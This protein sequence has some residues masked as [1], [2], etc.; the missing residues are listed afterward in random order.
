MEL[1]WSDDSIERSGAL[2]ALDK[3]FINNPDELERFETEN[4]SK[5]TR[6]T[7]A[8]YYSKSDSKHRLFK[9]A[10]D[11]DKDVR[12]T[13]FRYISNK[14]YSG[15]FI[16]GSDSRRKTTSRVAIEEEY[17]GLNMKK[18]VVLIPKRNIVE[19]AVS[20]FE[21]YYHGLYL[22]IE[23]TDGSFENMMLVPK[24]KPSWFSQE[25]IKELYS[26]IKPGQK[27]N[28]IDNPIITKLWKSLRRSL[29]KKPQQL[30]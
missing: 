10:K 29:P 13:V 4:A 2:E 1:T 21:E 9:Y 17:L 22:K 16:V 30:W 26:E 18:E 14:R 5:R 6:R 7:I 20:T 24:Y 25:T 8:Y 11:P 12:E 19:V 15:E 3:H 28:D 27:E 23:D